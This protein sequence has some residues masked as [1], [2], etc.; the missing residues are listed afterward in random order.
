MSKIAQLLAGALAALFAL[1]ACAVAP[2]ASTA[3]AAVTF[4][5]ADFSF[6]G[7]ESIPAGLTTINFQN[8]GKEWHHIQLARIND[9]VTMQQLDEA[10]KKDSNAALG[11][12]NLVGGVAALDPN[13]NGSVTLKLQEG[14][15]L[16]LCFIP[17][18]DGVPHLAKGMVRPLTVK[19]AGVAATEPSADITVDMK[20][21]HFT[22]PA[23]VKA[24]KQVWKVVNNGPQPHEIALVRLADGKTLEDIYAWYAKPEG[25]QPFS[26]AGGMQ[27]ISSVGGSGFIN[28]DLKPGN[29]VAICDIPDPASGKTHSELGMVMPFTVQ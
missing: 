6:E 4:K 28:L 16:L 9:G 7:P 19:G 8:I 12:V 25:P 22:M 26:M 24:G 29:Y 23:E 27:A 5:G 10:M 3:P 18:A 14:Q 15:Y 1:S 17:S 13:G 20:D 11:M 2:A 21:F